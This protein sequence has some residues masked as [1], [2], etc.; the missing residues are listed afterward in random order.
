MHRPLGNKLIE[1]REDVAR[2][3]RHEKVRAQRTSELPHYCRGGH[4]MALDITYHEGEPAFRK[5]DNVVEVAPDFR[6]L[7]S[8]YVPGRHAQAGQV[9]EMI[10]QQA[11]LQEMRNVRLFVELPGSLNDRSDL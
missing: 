1:K 9:A 4:I 5:V 8:G 3:L 2:I 7:A 6:F 11:G 10:R